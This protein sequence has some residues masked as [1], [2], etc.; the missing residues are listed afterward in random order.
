MTRRKPFHSL[1]RHLAGQL[2]QN[3]VSNYATMIWMAVLSVV[4]VPVYLRLLGAD[5][6]AIVAACLTMQGFLLLIDIGFSQLLPRALARAFGN[7]NAEARCF[8]VYTRLYI[9]LGLVGVVIAQV[10]VAPAVHHWFKVPSSSVGALAMALRLVTLQFLFQFSNNAN[11]GYWNGVQLQKRGNTRQCLFATARHLVALSSVWLIQRSALSYI[12]PFVLFAFVEWLAN[13]WSIRREFRKRGVEMPKVQLS[14]VLLAMKDGGGLTLGILVGMVVSQL[15]RIVLS[16]AL[17]LTRYG[18][19]LIVANLGMAFNQLQYPLMRAYFP[20]IVQEEATKSV[21]VKSRRLLM[22]GVA[23]LCILPCLLGFIF[24]PEI[25]QIWLKNADVL[26]V[27]VGP[28]RLILSAVVLNSV[29][30]VI[31]QRILARG[32]NSVVVIVNLAVLVTVVGEI[33]LIPGK[34]GPILGGIICISSSAT[35]LFA[36]C[37][38]LLKSRELVR[39]NVLKNREGT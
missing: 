20:R 27:G 29:Y 39:N 24:A 5:Q 6:W 25:L 33:C 3:I 22:L 36:G 30:H 31:Y 10:A 38:W 11:I 7:A 28:F 18:Y 4:T 16:T 35:Q 2:L 19:Y 26:A 9:T 12:I 14:E 1:R 23:V 13:T 17:D 32:E 15:D 37:I 21:S 8:E 34:V